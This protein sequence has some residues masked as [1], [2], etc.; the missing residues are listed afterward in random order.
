MSWGTCYSGSN[1]IHFDYP[2][3]MSDGR[4]YTDWNPSCEINKQFIKNHNIQTNYQY[5]QFLINNAKKIKESNMVS[6]CDNC[7]VCNYGYPFNA[8]YNGKYLFKSC[9][10]KHRPYG[11]ECSDLK[12]AY[13]S[14]QELQSRMIAPLMSQQGYLSLPN[15]N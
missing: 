1:N 14:R 10:D 13:L 6:A 5:R 8:D 4:N 15:P 11:Y 12:N 2:P 3:L 7:G 9:F